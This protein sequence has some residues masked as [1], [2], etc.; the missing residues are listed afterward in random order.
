MDDAQVAHGSHGKGVALARHLRKQS[1]DAE[2]LLWRHLRR[3][4]LEGFHFRRQ[5]P[6]GPYVVDFLCRS[7]KLAIE[8]DGGQH[9]ESA[10]RNRTAWLEARG[11]R[12]LRFW[13]NDLLANT[14]GV[15]E[16]IRTA[17]L[18]MAGR[19]PEP[20]VPLPIPPPEGE[21]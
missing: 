8:L 10:D 21:G 4:Q 11:Y 5:V 20:P 16:V 9:E 19:Q 17:A 7:L 6:L 1:T 13:N 3:G 18:S 14:A 2:R 12:V 15:L